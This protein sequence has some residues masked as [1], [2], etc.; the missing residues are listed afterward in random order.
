MSTNITHQ[1]SHIAHDQRSVSNKSWF[2]G[3]TVWFTGLS[4]AGKTTLAFALEHHLVNR[5]I[6]AYVLD[7]DN[8]RSGLNKN[9]GFSDEDRVENIRRVSEVA[10]LFAD[11][12]NICLTSFISPFESDRNAARMLHSQNNLPF[13]EVFLATPIEVCERRDVKG[14]YKRARAGEIKNFTGIS[15]IY[16]NPTNPDLILNTELYSVQECVSK[17]VQM[18]AT[19]GLVPNC[20]EV[21]PFGG[22]MPKELYVTDPL[23]V[24]KLKAQCLSLP[25]LEITELD[26]QWIQT[27]AEGWATPLNGFMR[28]NEYLQVL[29]FGQLQVSDCSVIT[30]F[31]IPIVLAI[32]NED[33][34]RFHGNGSSIAFVYKSNIIGMLQNCEFFPHRKEERCCHIF[35]TNHINHPTIKMIMSSGDWLVG[36]DLKVFER[37]KWNDGLDQYRLMP[38]ELHS[39]LVKMKADCVFAFQL[40]NPIH[41]GHALLMTETR[42]Q[43]LEKHGYH[44]PV[45]LLHPLGGWTKS[46]DVPLNI[47]IAQH[48]ACLDEGVLD[49]DTTLL[50]IFP[51]PML[52]AGP[53]EVQW[54]ARTRMLA[55]AQY[56]I[57]GRDPAG[58]PHPNGTG[59]DLYDPSHGAKVLSM[60]PGL[61]NLKIIPFRVAAYDKTINKMSFFDSKRSSDFLFISGTKMRTL[62][63]EGVEPPN[64]FM[65]EK[66]WKVLSNYYCQLN[67]SV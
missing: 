36:G 30:N 41:N 11:A 43:L 37:I 33:K 13:F 55:G 50:A 60:A 44:N 32:S 49:R 21:N 23:E 51:S 18:L 31:P 63:R 61:S 38:K 39:E 17:C 53:R 2:H 27:L 26:L 40:R 58:L 22:P 16:E 46:D 66:A 54:H 29:Y 47:R 35:G 64:G 10:R 24:Q 5:G 34:E 20:D 67:K 28:E 12:N 65:A 1:P 48:E 25:H 14:L 62:A 3:C 52:Y 8:I 59:V 7:G 4:G 9:L 45:L 6:S 57:V 15:A 56:Y 19:A 42:Q